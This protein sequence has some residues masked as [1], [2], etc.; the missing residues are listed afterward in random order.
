MRRTKIICTLGPASSSEEVVSA[1]IRAGLD[2][3]RF[4]FSHGTQQ[5]HRRG[6]ARV[7]SLAARLGRPVAVLQDLA[8]PKLRVGE[9][10]GG[11]AELRRGRPFT[12]TT[13]AI[14]GGERAASVA[15]PALPRCLKAGNRVLL[16]DGLLEL[17]VVDTTSTEVNC[18]VVTGG[19]LGSRKGINLPEVDLPISAVTEKD[20]SDLRLG[21]RLGVD[22]VAMSFVR[23]PEDLAPLRALMKRLGRRAPLLAKIEQHEAVREID[24]IIAAADGVMV[25]RGDLGVE[26]PVEQVPVLQKRIIEKCNRAGKPVVVATQMLDSMIRNPRPTRAEVSDI[27]NAILDGADALML[28]G[29][30]SVGKYPLAAVRTMV[31]TARRA[32]GALDFARLLQEKLRL[33]TRTLTDAISQATCELAADLGARAI[34][35][36][37]S[38]G[39]TAVMV[40]RHRPKAPIVAVTPNVAT[41]RRM[42]LCWGVCPL[43]VPRGRST[44]EMLRGAIAAARKA[45]FVKD[46]DTVVVTAGVPAGVAGRTNLI[47]VETVGKHVR[48]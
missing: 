24:E 6:I 32:E 8:G 47:K 44:D 46:G 2:G 14:I 27:A 39:H 36:S 13:R 9:M 5:E 18:R 37:T 11:C 38:T 40:S 34:I 15:F 12:L 23:R 22:W 20:L 17:E 3:A 45:G 30:T 1:L 16:D 33:P 7:R 4:N 29:E 19:P 28:S 41:Q 35:T 21:L 31:R 43:L 10:A 42:A 25:A 48:L 26:L